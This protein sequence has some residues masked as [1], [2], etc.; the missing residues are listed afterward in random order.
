MKKTIGFACV[1]LSGVWAS[2]ATSAEQPLANE[3]SCEAGV[4]GFV[5][6]YAG[7][8]DVFPGNSEVVDRLRPKLK[9]ERIAD[10]VF[11]FNYRDAFYIPTGETTYHYHVDAA[12]CGRASYLKIHVPGIG[13]ELLRLSCSLNPDGT[14]KDFDLSETDDTGYYLEQITNGEEP[15]TVSLEPTPTSQDSNV[16]SHWDES[17]KSELAALGN[18]L[19]NTMND[20]QIK[21]SAWKQPATLSA[22]SDQGRDFANREKQLGS[23]RNIEGL[24]VQAKNQIGEFM[25]LIASLKKTVNPDYQTPSASNPEGFSPMSVGEGH[26]AKL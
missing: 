21:G 26:S 15:S 17:I 8:L 4:H 12:L 10:Q 5:A 1:L 24:D 18:S 7:W 9:S 22:L 19:Q 3:F 23:C 11:A 14:L 2:S 25:K 6:D 16:R 13:Q 20:P